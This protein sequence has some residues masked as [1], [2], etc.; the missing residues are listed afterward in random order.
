[1]TT[2]ELKT[3]MEKALAGTM[4]ELIRT[5]HRSRISYLAQSLKNKMAS[6][7]KEAEV[8]DDVITLEMERQAFEA[9][10]AEVKLSAQRRLFNGI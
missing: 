10:C 8:V 3:E 4:V 6:I 2:D 7:E 5:R 9:K 1:M